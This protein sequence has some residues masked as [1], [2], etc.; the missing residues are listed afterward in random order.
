MNVWIISLWILSIGCTIYLTE[1]SCTRTQAI[2]FQAD[3]AHASDRAELAYF[4]QPLSIAR[5]ELEEFDSQLRDYDYRFSDD[6][7]SLLWDRFLTRAR[8]AKVSRDLQEDD[9]SKRYL[10]EAFATGVELGLPLN[11]VA[12]V[13]D[14]LAKM[15][16]RAHSQ[17]KNSRQ[18]IEAGPAKISGD[19]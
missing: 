12:D 4:T 11:Q 6:P 18:E 19:K 15:D 17:Y 3:L 8:L 7:K 2:F 9:A 10:D 1:Q 16:Q 13:W 14:A 5:W